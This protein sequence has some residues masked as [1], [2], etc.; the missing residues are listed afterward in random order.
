MGQVLSLSGARAGAG[1]ET[2]I[3]WC[4][5]IQSENRVHHIFYR[6]LVNVMLLPESTADKVLDPSSRYVLSV[7]YQPG[8]P[9]CRHSI[10]YET[11]HNGYNQVFQAIDPKNTAVASNDRVA[12]QRLR[13]SPTQALRPFITSS[14]MASRGMKPAPTTA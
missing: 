13:N 2:V 10:C 5:S 1:F 11:A 14:R 3:I 8:A 6:M 12:G 9:A 7:T 4:I